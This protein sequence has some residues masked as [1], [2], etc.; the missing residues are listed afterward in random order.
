MGCVVHQE[1]FTTWLSAS[2]SDEAQTPRR[3]LLPQ[4]AGDA[5][6]NDGTL[7]FVISVDRDLA[8]ALVTSAVTSDFEHCI[9]VHQLVLLDPVIADDLGSRIGIDSDSLDLSLRL[10]LGLRQVRPRSL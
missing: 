2:A 7:D 3:C 6:V 10:D 8:L 1:T 4:S 5:N 9:G